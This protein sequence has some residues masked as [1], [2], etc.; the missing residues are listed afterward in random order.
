MPQHVNAAGTH[1]LRLEAL[2][3]GCRSPLLLWG[4][5]LNLPP[6]PHDL[7]AP[8]L[9]W[10]MGNPIMLPGDLMQGEDALIRQDWTHG[11]C[12]PEDPLKGPCSR[13]WEAGDSALPAHVWLLL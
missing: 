9:G 10:G 1:L 11:C 6:P 3:L 12:F 13:T 8:G 5:D 2:Q 7:L 4:R